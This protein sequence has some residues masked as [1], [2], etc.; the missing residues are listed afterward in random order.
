M[1]FILQPWPWYV[2]GP[3]IGLIML[4]LT[5]FGKSFGM[6]SNLRTLC[7]LGGAGKFSDFFKFDI[8]AQNWNLIVVLGVILG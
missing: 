7:A 5:Y 3:L 6:S 8:K 1:E 2:S 4:A